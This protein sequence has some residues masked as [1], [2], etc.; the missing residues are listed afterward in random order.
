MTN[1]IDLEFKLKKRIGKKAV[2]KHDMATGTITG[3]HVEATGQ[4]NQPYVVKYLIAF[5]E[6]ERLYLADESNVVIMK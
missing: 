1:R 3:F 6:G 5:D 4:I 2:T